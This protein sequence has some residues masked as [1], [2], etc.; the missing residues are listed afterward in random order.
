LLFANNLQSNIMIELYSDS[1][2]ILKKISKIDDFT[3][4]KTFLKGGYTDSKNLQNDL[5]KF[6][7]FNKKEHILNDIEIK[8]LLEIIEKL[9]VYKPAPVA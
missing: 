9:Q 4:S 5:E 3:Y 2:T 8:K 7:K 1:K 6:I